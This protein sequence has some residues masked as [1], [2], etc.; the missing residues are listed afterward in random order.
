MDNDT[1]PTLPRPEDMPPLTTQAD[2]QGFWRAMMSEQDFR[3][4]VADC[5]SLLDG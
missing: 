5:L 3:F 4:P 1:I 2:V